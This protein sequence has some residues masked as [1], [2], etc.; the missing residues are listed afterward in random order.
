MSGGSASKRWE[1]P[2][3]VPQ[4]STTSRPTS[5]NKLLRYYRVMV[6][7]SQNQLARAAGVDPAYVNRLERAPDDST[8]MPSR[9]VVFALYG[10]VRAEALTYGY[11]IGEQDLERLLVSA[12][13]VPE[14]IRALGGWDAYLNRVRKTFADVY[15]Q[16]NLSLTATEGD[17]GC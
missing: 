5:F 17:D 6:G 10:A 3:F 2:R 11:H 16:L 1:G 7:M 4:P 14:V 12:G 9:K 8:S 13:H 15:D